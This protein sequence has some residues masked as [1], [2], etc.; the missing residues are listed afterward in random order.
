MANP[1]KEQQEILNK[2]NIQE[3]NP[4]QEEAI[5]VID[6]TANTIILF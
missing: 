4:M 1:I 2:F 6:T 5:S 3:L